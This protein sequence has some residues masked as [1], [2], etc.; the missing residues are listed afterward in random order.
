MPVTSFRRATL[1]REIE[2]AINTV[3]M[4]QVALA[5]IERAHRDASI[6]RHYLR[7]TEKHLAALRQDRSTWHLEP[8]IGGHEDEHAVPP[9]VAPKC[10]AAPTDDGFR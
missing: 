4:L 5:E 7:E 2:Q 9:V 8:R 3:G 1:D 10:N 6:E